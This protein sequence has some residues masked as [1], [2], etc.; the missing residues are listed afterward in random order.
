MPQP[1]L[2]PR[3]CATARAHL[4]N[5]PG[6][7]LNGNADNENANAGKHGTRNDGNHH[8]ASDAGNPP[9]NG[10]AGNAGNAGNNGGDWG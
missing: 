3:G 5:N 7:P 1:K 2:D 8:N 4:G 9:N 10:N 6:K